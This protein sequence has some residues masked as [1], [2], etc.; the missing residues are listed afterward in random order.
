MSNFR[1][2]DFFKTATGHE[3]FDHQCRLAGGDAGTACESKL[4]EI[5]TG[6]GKTA[7]VVLAWLRNRVVVPTLN[8][9]PPV[10][11]SPQGEGGSTITPDGL[12][13]CF[14]PTDAHD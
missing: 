1:F 7:G 3:P 8:T 14:G 4:I 6:Q 5:P 11:R 9:Q 13:L 2:D 10:R 12:T